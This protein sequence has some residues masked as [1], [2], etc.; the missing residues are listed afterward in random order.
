MK[1][2]SLISTD[3]YKITHWL[4]RPTN[5]TKL[6]SYAEARRGG[7]HSEICFE[8]IQP[9]IKNYFLPFFTEENIKEGFEESL[10]C[11]GNPNYFPK[12]IWERVLKLGYYPIRIKAVK[13]GTV[14]PVSNVLFTIESTE[15]WFAG[16]VSHFED[17]LMWCWYSSAVATRAYNIRKNIIPAFEKSQENPYYGFAVNDFGYRGAKFHEAAC[18]GGAGFLTFFDGT[19]NLAARKFIKDNYGTAGIGQSVWATEHSV[20]TVWGPGKGEFGYI[21]AQLERAGD[22]AIVSI[23]IDSY[24]SDN[25]IKNVVGNPEI[26]ELIIKRSGRTVLRP[27][28][29]DPLENVIKYSEMLGNIFGYHLNKKQYK[30]LNHNIGIIQGDGMTETSIPHLYN[31]YVKAGW[32]TE[33]V[34]TGSGGGLLTEGLTRDTD[35]WAIKASYA[36]IDNNSIEVRKTPKTDMTKQSKGGKLKLH[37]T[38]GAFLTL[39]SVKETSAMFNSYTDELEVVYENGQLMR[40]QTFDE[41]RKI[42]NSYL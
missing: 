25:F 7:Q 31:E 22:S 11:F 38:G 14:V 5:L 2:N 34:V 3:A 15:P 27:D 20:A 23:V 41:I 40:D 17:W 29:G 28:S 6:Y 9:I 13:E 19:D 10:S 42:A 39:E 37:K 4:Q 21:K 24:D 18:Y 32:S 35:R 16:M 1:F 12:E 30:V 36:E 33:N 26:K 8:G